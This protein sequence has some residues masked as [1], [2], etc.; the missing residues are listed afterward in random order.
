MLEGAHVGT[1][2]L[3]CPSSE[4]RRSP[5]RRDTG[6]PSF[7]IH[8]G[9]EEQNAGKINWQPNNKSTQVGL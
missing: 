8:H 2:A 1:A 6:P 7:A 4:A 5:Q 3:G 9:S